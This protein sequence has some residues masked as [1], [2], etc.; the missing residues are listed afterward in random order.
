MNKGKNKDFRHKELM[1]KLPDSL[2]ESNWPASNMRN[3]IPPQYPTFPNPSDYDQ[4]GN[5]LDDINR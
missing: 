3:V 5:R 1:Q 4:F 2:D